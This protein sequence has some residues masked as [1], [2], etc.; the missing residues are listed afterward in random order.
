VDLV[1]KVHDRTAATRRG[2]R[3]GSPHSSLPGDCAPISAR[4]DDAS[5]DSHATSRQI[6]RSGRNIRCVPQRHRA[7]HFD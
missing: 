7:S 1:G 5:C 3:Q 6:R 4:S 2:W